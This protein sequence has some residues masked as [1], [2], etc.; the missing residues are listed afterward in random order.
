MKKFL[1][2]QK[3]MSQRVRHGRGGRYL[4]CAVCSTRVPKRLM[5]KHLLSYYHN[6]YIPQQPQLAE[7]LVLQYFHLI[8]KE[9]PFKCTLCSFYCNTSDNLLLHFSSDMHHTMDKLV[10]FYAD[11]TFLI[12]VSYGRFQLN[13]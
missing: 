12:S 4:F 3:A 6:T 1:S 7:S 5:G 2:V 10:K 13:V 9:S 8:V 11:K